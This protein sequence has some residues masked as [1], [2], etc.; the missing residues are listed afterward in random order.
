[1]DVDRELKGVGAIHAAFDNLVSHG[2]PSGA[3]HVTVSIERLTRLQQHIER[4]HQSLGGA[5]TH[6]S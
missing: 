3:K 6:K 1:M 5:S 2:K 4:L